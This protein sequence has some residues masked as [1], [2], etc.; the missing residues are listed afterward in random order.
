MSPGVDDIDSSRGS[1][2]ADNDTTEA[3]SILSLADDIM[4]LD[5]TGP[6]DWDVI[7]SAVSFVADI[8]TS[9]PEL[10]ALYEY[11]INHLDEDRF[12]SNHRRLLKDYY[13]MLNSQAHTMDQTSSIGFLRSR[14][15]RNMISSKILKSL[16]PQK[17][18]KIEDLTAEM[19]NHESRDLT[20]E[21]YLT[22]PEEVYTC[23]CGDNMLLDVKELSLGGV[24]HAWVGFILQPLKSLSKIRFYKMSTGDFVKF[25]LVPVREEIVPRGFKRTEFPPCAEVKSGNYLYRPV[26]MG[27]VELDFIPLSHLTLPGKHSDDGWLTMFPKKL[28]T[29]LSRLPGAAN[30]SVVGCGIIVNEV[31]NWTHFVLLAL[32]AVVLIG[33]VVAV[34]WGISSDASSAFGLGAFLVAVCTLSISLNYSYW[35]D[36]LQ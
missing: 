32:I 9:D 28:Q 24:H 2:E 3:Q 12:M 1:E 5:D 27:D 7:M 6:V 11:A 30:P 10:M 4:S 18:T 8:L 25:H 29:P 35:Q 17:A 33:I 13:I 16:S 14:K 34:Y 19:Q 15:H 20:L 21:R 31:F 36:S 26:P 22:G 23:A